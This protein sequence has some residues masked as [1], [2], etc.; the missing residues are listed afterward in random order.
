MKKASIFFF[1]VLLVAF[2]V[3]AQ[4]TAE[5]RSNVVRERLEQARDAVKNVTQ[6]QR[7][8][9]KE[10]ALEVQQKAQELRQ[11]VVEQFQAKRLEV[12]SQIKEKREEVRNAVET[13]RA[14]V[15]ATVE[16]KRTELRDRLSAVRDE[17]KKAVVERLYDNLNALNKR[18]VDL[19]FSK[20]E[21]IENILDRVRSRADKAEAH[22]LDVSSA[23]DEIAAAQQAIERARAVLRE[24]AGKSYTIEV[25][26]ETTLRQ[27]VQAVK[28]QLHAD[29]AAARDAVKAAMEA[30][31]KA[32]VAL[33]QIPRVNEVEVSPQA[34]T[35]AAE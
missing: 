14:E 11:N 25:T 10:R 35:E 13:K 24:Q 1:P 6:E 26:D 34:A 15:K 28:E 20:L 17:R 4:T 8:E 19:L 30:V 9:V 16:Q 5:P 33:A 3:S 21:H 32:A 12:K 31:R 7:E 23:R 29:L 22:D 2:V 27:K 18:M